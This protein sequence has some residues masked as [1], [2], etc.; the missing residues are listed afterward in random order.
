MQNSNELLSHIQL[1]SAET[2]NG[3]SFRQPYCKPILEELGDL[4][5]LTLGGSP[6]AGDSGGGALTCDPSGFGCP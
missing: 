6:G 2:N 3:N 1:A 5:T 4:R